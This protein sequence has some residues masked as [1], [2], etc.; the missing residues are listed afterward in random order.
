MSVDYVFR[1]SRSWRPGPMWRRHRWS[2]V[3]PML[4]SALVGLG[5]LL[6]WRG[7]DLPAQ[8]YRITQVRQH[9][10]TLWDSQ[11]YGGHWTFNYSVIFPATA[12]VIG[13]AAI[14]L[15]SAAAASLAFDRLVVS[16]FGTLARVAS[17]VFAASTIVEMAIGQLPFLFGEAWGLWCL[18]AA[19][20]RRWVSA[21]ILAVATSL[22]SPLAG[23][24]LALAGLTWLLGAWHRRRMLLIV[25]AAAVL[26]IALIEILFQGQGAM[27]FPVVDFVWESVVAAGLWLLTPRSEATLRIGIGVYTAALVGSFLI[28]TAVGGNV[29]R[30]EDLLALPIAALLLWPHRRFVLAAVA[31]PLV[32]AQ[33]RPAWAA[34]TTESAQPSTHRAY[35]TPL[36]TWLDSAGA[37][38]GRVEVVPTEYHWEATYVAPTIALARGW[39][40]QLDVGNDQLFY[41]PGA[42]NAGSYLAWLRNNGVRY[43]ALPDAPLDYAARAEGSLVRAGVPGLQPLWHDA[44]WEVF[45]VD[46]SSGIVDG[47]ARLISVNGGQVDLQATAPG[48]VLVR[49]RYSKDWHL[50]AGIGCVAPA[51]N[52]WTAVSV[53]GAEEV[54]LQLRLLAGVDDSCPPPPALSPAATG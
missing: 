4:A 47:P 2:L 37:A 21:A 20:R 53:P 43:V 10:I 9:G 17:V 19:L 7:V 51:A 44:H 26:P 1:G 54:H 29:G 50:T 5:T 23:A 31:I 12:A 14:A 27:P 49:V 35:Y 28:P 25:L 3:A 11:W 45:G 8:L 46:G 34:M 42:L 13:V 36:V 18:L 39:E 22:S 6:G 33:W 48:T 32:F 40:R 24:F 16:H 41:M 52:N 15:I 38:A 30:L